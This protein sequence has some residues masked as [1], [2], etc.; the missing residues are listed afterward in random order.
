MAELDLYEVLGVNRSAQA[1]ELKRAY[2]G[3]AR[4][5]HPDANPDDPAAE[6]RFKEIS[7]A[8]EVL[9]DPEKRARYDQFGI[10]GLQGAGGGGSPFGFP[11][12]LAD[13]FGSF[14]GSSMGRQGRPRGPMAGQDVQIAMTLSFKEAIF[15]A[16]KELVVQMPTS[17]SSCSGLGS[18]AGSAATTCGE[19]KGHGE[20]RRVRQSILGQMVT[21]TA[22]PGCGGWGETLTNPCKN[23]GG[24]G[25]VNDTVTMHVDVPAGVDEGSTLHLSGQG[26]AGPRGGPQG[27]LYVHLRVEADERFERQGEHVHMALEL[28]VTQAALG[29]T[30]E[31]E[32]L[33]G[34]AE[35]GVEAGTQSGTIIRL[36]GEG[37][38]HLPGRGRGRGDLFVHLQVAT[39]TE[40]TDAERQLLRDL[41][42]ARGEAIDEEV[43]A[44]GLLKK[45]RSALS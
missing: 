14:F 22:C 40:L 20:V 43:R 33:D 12:D 34:L 29:A 30:L 38:P 28:A 7:L 4:K 35:V 3:L 10:D 26:A 45:I 23:C 42:A 11:E 41:A 44:P 37:V 9:S 25:R 18:E 13:L 16:S 31:I 15:G 19:C 2:R 5:F 27:S 17:C 6:A 32:T 8:Y 1:D 36:R 39:P 21:T 24:E